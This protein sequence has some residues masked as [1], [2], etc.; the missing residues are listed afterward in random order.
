MAVLTASVWAGVSLLL[1]AADPDVADLHL[2]Q[3]QVIGTHNS[4][5]LRP[6]SA[7]LQFAQ[8]VQPAA[9]EWDYSRQTLAEQLDNGIRSFELDLH[10]AGEEWLVMHVPVLD[11]QSSVRT[12]RD[13]LS[14]V[15]DWS[16]QHPRHIPISLLLELKDEGIA[17]QRGI[18]APELADLDQLDV[19]LREILG[20]RLLTPDDVRGSFANLADAAAA[21][22]WPTLRQCAGKVFV[23]L[24]EVGRNRSLY[25]SG[26][27]ALQGRAMFVNSQPGEPDG[28]T[29]VMDNPRHADIASSARIGVIIRTRADNRQTTSAE[30][31]DAALASG[32][33][34]LS[35]DHPRGEASPDTSFEFQGG[36]PARVNPVTGPSVLA[37]QPLTEPIPE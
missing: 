11:A 18:R 30:R 6:P 36:A 21:H 7:V 27:P 9:K 17:L 15:R 31:R 1:F 2:H 22:H 16:D 32:A 5:H 10:L 28:A 34:I 25:R 35:T 29:S 13:A 20:K 12:F 8:R 23:I 26:R 19:S 24:H 3:I 33:H 37:G 14:A 4:Y